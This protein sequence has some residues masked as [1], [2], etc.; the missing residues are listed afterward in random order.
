MRK[1]LVAMTTDLR[2]KI[3]SELPEM[4]PNVKKVGSILCVTKFSSTE[5]WSTQ[6]WRSHLKYLR[7]LKYES[8]IS[9]LRKGYRIERE[10]SFGIRLCF[11]KILPAAFVDIAHDKIGWKGSE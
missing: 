3:L 8:L 5:D 2:E 1:N 10:N 7:T 6:V 4:H 9:M 11:R